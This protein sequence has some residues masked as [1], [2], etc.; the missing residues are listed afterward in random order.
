MPSSSPVA[1]GKTSHYA[2]IAVFLHWAL[3]ILTFGMVGLGWYMMSIEDV[4]GSGWYFDLHKSIGIIIAVLVLLRGVWRLGHKPEALPASVPS[5]QATASRAI[6]WLLYVAMVAMPL[7]GAIG[8]ML[9]KSGIAF[10]GL[11]MPRLFAPNHDFAELFFTAHSIIAW[12][13]V[14][15][16]SAHVLAA[17][18]H[19]VIDKDGV[20]QRMWFGDSGKT[21]GNR[22]KAT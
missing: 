6:H 1:M 10:F 16:I 15:L 21:S 14:G 3:A 20:F 12:V 22:G 5:W 2:P 11:T 4:P 18:K 8:A 19:L 9:S 7:A 17:I 13:M